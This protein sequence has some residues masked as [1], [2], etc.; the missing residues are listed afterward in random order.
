MADIAEYWHVFVKMFWL[1]DFFLLHLCSFCT[2]FTHFSCTL[3]EIMDT[4]P[5]KEAIIL[6]SFLIHTLI[7]MIF[8][9]L[10]LKTIIFQVAI[11]PLLVAL[12]LNALK[13]PRSSIPSHEGLQGPKWSWKILTLISISMINTNTSSSHA[14]LQGPKC[15]WNIHHQYSSNRIN[16]A[17]CQ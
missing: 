16:F 4:Q 6:D 13:A 12:K 7:I 1:V 17:C 14:G 8:A 2:Q 15:S 10:T 5:W 11:R 9:I 3:K